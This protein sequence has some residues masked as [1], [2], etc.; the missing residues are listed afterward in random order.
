ML[1]ILALG[2]PFMPTDPKIV[3]PIQVSREESKRFLPADSVPGALGQNSGGRDPRLTFR[4]QA[5]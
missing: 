5:G 2:S 1:H 4:E 3:L